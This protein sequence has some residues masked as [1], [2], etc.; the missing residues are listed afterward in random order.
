MSL[1]GTVGSMRA[2]MPKKKP[3]AAPTTGPSR[4]AP[5]MTG[6]CM[7]V[8]L[9]AAVGTGMNPMRVSSSS[10]QTAARTPATTM[11]LT[12]RS[13]FMPCLLV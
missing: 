5:M 8:A 1:I 3:M 9:P 4:M 10:P 2:K 12:V 11:R 7:M 13:M 6:T